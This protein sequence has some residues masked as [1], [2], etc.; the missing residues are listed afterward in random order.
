MQA[1]KGLAMEKRLCLAALVVAGLLLLVFLI[2]LILNLPLGLRSISPAVD[3]VLML[4]SALLAYL[5]W[6]AL[7]DQ[8]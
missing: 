5:A 3:I 6:D 4:C 2:D 1:L 8:L 7:R